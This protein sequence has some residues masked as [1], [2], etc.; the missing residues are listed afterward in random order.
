MIFVE[1]FFADLKFGFLQFDATVK[2][3]FI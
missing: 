2:E 3:N 1:N